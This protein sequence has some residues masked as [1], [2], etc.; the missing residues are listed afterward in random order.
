MVSDRPRVVVLGT[1]EGTAAVA[2][3][4]R[5]SVFTHAAALAATPQEDGPPDAL[6]YVAP[7]PP[8]PCLGAAIAT[9]TATAVAEFVSAVQWAA[10]GMARRGRGG[11]IVIVLDV[12]GVPGRQGHAARATLSGALIGAGKCLAKELGRQHISVNMVAHGFIAELG[13]LDNLDKAERKL[14]DMMN[15]GKTGSV[16]QLA[17]NIAHLIGNDHLVTGQVL[18]ADDGLII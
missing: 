16:A 18:H 9:Y 7:L 13:S 2:Q 1:N 3:A 4:L 10:K 14:F 12:A 17:R 5:A 6:V 8:T 15:L 11:A